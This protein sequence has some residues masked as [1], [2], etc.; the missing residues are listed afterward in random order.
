MK[1]VLNETLP[2]ENELNKLRAKL[3]EVFFK[4]SLFIFTINIVC[5]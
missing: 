3:E 1:K 4:N 5:F 2:K